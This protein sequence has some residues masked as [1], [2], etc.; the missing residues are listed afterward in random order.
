MFFLY[1]D[2]ISYLDE[3]F[4]PCATD[5]KPKFPFTSSYLFSLETQHTIGYGFKATTEECPSAIILVAIQV[6]YLL[7]CHKNKIDRLHAVIFIFEA[8]LHIW[9]AMVSKVQVLT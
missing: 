2:H 6:I 9:F 4:T 5:L 7:F 3:N 8:T 1:L